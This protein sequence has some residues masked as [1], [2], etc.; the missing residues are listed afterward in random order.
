MAE[1]MTLLG[2]NASDDIYIEQLRENFEKRILVINDEINEGVIEDYILRIMD[3]NREDKYIPVEE[4]QVISLYINSPGGNAF[5][6]NNFVDVIQASVTPV[7]AVC[8]GIAASMAFHI[9][10][11]CSERVAFKSSTLLMHDG[12]IQIANSTSKARDTMRFF[13][14][15]E[16]RTKDHVLSNTKMTSEY[17]DKHY[18]TELYLYA[19]EAKEL[20]CVDKIIG[21][22]VDLDYIL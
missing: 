7:R 8:F 20:G 4:R 11:A 3:W 9:F 17:Y 18:D 5:D 21:E 19:D 13:E 2:S 1:L 10:I 15:M 14:N 12:N 22:D 6:G 16:K